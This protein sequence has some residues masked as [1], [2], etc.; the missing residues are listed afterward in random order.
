MEEVPIEMRDNTI[1]VLFSERRN[2]GK[3][4]IR[5]ENKSEK[6]DK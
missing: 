5:A 3:A 6:R 4:I 1:Q 2:K